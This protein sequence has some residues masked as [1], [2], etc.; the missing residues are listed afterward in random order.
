M[1]RVEMEKK[2]NLMQSRMK[3]QEIDLTSLREHEE[4]YR[5][6]RTLKDD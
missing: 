3:M 2:I 5:E 6:L 4:K 1:E